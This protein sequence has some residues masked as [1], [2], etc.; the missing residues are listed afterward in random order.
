MQASSSAQGGAQTRRVTHRHASTTNRVSMG[1]GYKW[2]LAMG[3]ER[4]NKQRVFYQALATHLPV[5]LL[6]LEAPVKGGLRLAAGL[7]MRRLHLPSRL[8]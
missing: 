5:L 6:R 8:F 1:L 7:C 3:G 2:A 4:S